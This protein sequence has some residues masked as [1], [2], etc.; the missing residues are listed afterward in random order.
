MSNAEARNFFV[1]ATRVVSAADKGSQVSYMAPDGTVHLWFPGN[2]RV[3]RG[4][5]SLEAAGY[6]VQI[7]ARPVDAVNV[8]FVYGPDSYNAWTG[9]RGRRTCVPA[10]SLKGLTQDRAEGDVFRLS[11]ATAAPFVLPQERTT[12][13]A[14]KARIR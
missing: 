9:E 1:G 6:Y 12:I 4:R 11:Q 8:C 14:L 5:W 7:L 3:V 10:D 2:G 13:A